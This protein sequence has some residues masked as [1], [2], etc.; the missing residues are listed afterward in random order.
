MDFSIIRNCINQPFLD[1]FC[2]K[3]GQ[4]IGSYYFKMIHAKNNIQIYIEKMGENNQILLI[5][6][7]KNH[8]YK[9]YPCSKYRN[10]K[11]VIYNNRLDELEIENLLISIFTES[12][13][14]KKLIS[15]EEFETNG[16]FLINKLRNA[17]YNPNKQLCQLKLETQYNQLQNY[18]TIGV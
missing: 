18:S 16:Y 15:K 8:S 14:N 11:V 12:Y 13:R 10:E 9:F 3:W 1:V 4:I 6:N 2:N 17:Y 7:Y 5:Y